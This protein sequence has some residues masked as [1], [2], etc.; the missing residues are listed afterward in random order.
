MERNTSIWSGCE[1]VLGT[2]GLIEGPKWYPEDSPGKQ[3]RNRNKTA[4][5]GSEKEFRRYCDNCMMDRRARGG[6]EHPA[7]DSQKVLLDELLRRCQRM[8]QTA[9]SLSNRK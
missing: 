7:Q 3:R 8:L 4:I 2:M 6:E 5:S 1:G 9:Q